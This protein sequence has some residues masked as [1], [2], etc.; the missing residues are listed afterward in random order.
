MV[1]I[2]AIWVWLEPQQLA[3]ITAAE[4]KDG[5]PRRALRAVDLAALQRL[6]IHR[7]LQGEIICH[8]GQTV[9]VV[10]SRGRKVVADLTPV[11]G[12]QAAAVDPVI[13]TMRSGIVLQVTPQVPEGGE[14]AVLDLRSVVSQA[15]AAGET[16]EI[17][18]MST[19]E[20]GQMQVPV[21]DRAQHLNQ[22]LATTVKVPQ[23]QA[24]L[25]GGMSSDPA[26]A[27]GAQ[28][29]LVIRASWD[30]E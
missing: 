7:R 21:V 9:H 22:E 25:V 5:K 18:G 27:A 30:Q 6:D 3:E 12:T 19:A 29:Y 1:R 14:I 26:E 16:I 17:A 8:N 23:G 24:V 20:A 2:E 11:V 15:E 13:E 4:G 28:L 10:S